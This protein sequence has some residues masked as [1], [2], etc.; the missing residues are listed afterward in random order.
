[1]AQA[2]FSALNKLWH[3][4]TYSTQTKFRIFNTNVKAVLLYGCE[5]WKKSK[6]IKTKLQVF[7]NKCLRK[8]LR[9]FWPGQ[10]TNNDLWKRKNQTM[11]DL[12]IRKRKWNGWAIHCGNRLKI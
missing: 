12:Q 4:A 10:I 2:A 9:I 8:I 5:T 7:I 1:M 6:Y 3:S 11:I